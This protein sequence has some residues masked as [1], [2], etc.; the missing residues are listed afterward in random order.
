[1]EIRVLKPACSPALIC[2]DFD[3]TLVDSMP[4]LEKNAVEVI[5]EYFDMSEAEARQKYLLTSGLPF[6]QQ[7]EIVF[8]AEPRE[9]RIAAVNDFENLKKECLM[10]AQLFPKT[11]EVIKQLK[12]R[13]FKI[14]ISSSSKQFEIWEYLVKESLIE[15]IDQVLGF[16]PGFEKGKEHIDYLIK[17]EAVTLEQIWFVGDSLNDMRWTYKAGVFFIAMTGQIFNAEDFRIK[18]NGDE[19]V[20]FLT[21]DNLEELF[22]ILR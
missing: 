5:R 13:G 3:G 6:V 4:L 16:Q 22:S 1:M 21:I 17:N 11:R 12:E 14:A 18:I 9:K 10:Q 7:V 20:Q 15:Y 8:P 2:L 19:V